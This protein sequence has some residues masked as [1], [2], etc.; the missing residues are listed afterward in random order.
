[1]IKTP[2]RSNRGA[3]KEFTIGRHAFAK[4]SAI[5]GVFLTDEM[6]RDFREFEQK[7]LSSRERRDAI[8]K[9]V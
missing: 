2:G 8:R 4:I 3:N 1:M 9:K 6:E 7:G 5:E